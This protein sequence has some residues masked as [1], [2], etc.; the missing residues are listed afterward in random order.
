MSALEGRRQQAREAA[1]DAAPGS[2]TVADAVEAA[3]ETATRVRLTPEIE[4]SAQAARTD[5][6]ATASDV[7]RAVLRAAGFEVEG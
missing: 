5:P 7:A 1:Q 3:I 6:R 2:G 4:D